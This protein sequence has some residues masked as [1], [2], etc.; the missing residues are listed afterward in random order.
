MNVFIEAIKFNHDPA[1]ATADALNIRKNDDE[2]SAFPEWQRGKSFRAEDSVAAYA[3]AKTLGQTISIKAKF[4]SNNP[5]LTK[6]EVQ[7]VDPNSPPRN[8]L[9]RVEIA[10][11]TFASNGESDFVDFL[12]RD[13]LLEQRGVG[14]SKNIWKWQFRATPDS[15]W[16][17]FAKTAHKIYTVLDEPYDPWSQDVS[18][19]DNSQLPWTEV[20]D[21]ACDWADSAQNAPQAAALITHNT[22]DLGYGFVTYQGNP[23]SY[24]HG[25]FDCTNF[26]RLLRGQDGMGK[27][28]NCSDCATIVTSL[29]NILGCRTWEVDLVPG[30]ATNPIIIIG[31]SAPGPFGFVGHEVTL[32]GDTLDQAMVFDAL[33]QIDEDEDPAH[34]NHFDAV[35]PANLPFGL[36]NEHNY[37]FRVSSANNICPAFEVRHRRKIG[38]RVRAKFVDLDPRFIE[39]LKE[40]FDYESWR[41]KEGPL[42]IAN[43]NLLA[44]IGSNLLHGWLRVDEYSQTFGDAHLT[45]LLWKPP[46]L[47]PEVL[48]RTDIF[49]CPG[50]REARAVLLRLLGE[51]RSTPVEELKH[52]VF[53]DV[54][55]IAKDNTGLLFAHREWVVLIR[56]AGTNTI[57]LKESISVARAEAFFNLQIQETNT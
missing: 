32:T 57:F 35:L 29:A 52:P 24:A 26:L 54:E 11:V 42:E 10:E 27:T 21:V 53:A 25:N 30:F 6:I 28:F 34:S 31:E 20:L 3:I 5:A 44:F 33:L 39:F 48:V 40:H 22:Y 13:V 38:N 16:R 2:A 4:K 36:P 19:G 17:D 9:G 1:S 51:F 15:P 18:N 14:I 41:D 56:S 55:F 46:S 49:E 47:D 43:F 7:A 45:Q 23:S 8:V 12:L 50:V 37:R